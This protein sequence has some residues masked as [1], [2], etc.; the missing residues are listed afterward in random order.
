MSKIFC[1]RWE[2]LVGV[3]AA[4]VE[5]LPGHVGRLDAETSGLLLVTA[6]SLLL[7]AVLNWPRVL[8]R[9]A[10]QRPCFEAIGGGR[11]R[12]SEAFIDKSSV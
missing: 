5:P 8:P 9:P 4:G 7:R 12:V 11:K 3:G 2:L 10:A 1:F 6:D